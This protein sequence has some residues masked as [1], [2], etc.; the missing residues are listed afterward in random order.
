MD[1]DGESDKN[2]KMKE[3]EINWRR[4]ERDRSDDKLI[5]GIWRQRKREGEGYDPPVTPPNYIVGCIMILSAGKNCA[6]GRAV[7]RSSVTTGRIWLKMEM[8]SV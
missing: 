4:K 3:S 8:G 7:V 6:V 1:V 2:K 5:M